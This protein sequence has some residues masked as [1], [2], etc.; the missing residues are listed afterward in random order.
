MYQGTDYG[1]CANK[2]KVGC[3][4]PGPTGETDRQF[5]LNHCNWKPNSRQLGESCN[6]DSQ[7]NDISGSVVGC[8]YNHGNG[9]AFK[10]GKEEYRYS[11]DIQKGSWKDDADHVFYDMKRMNEE[12]DTDQS[13]VEGLYFYR[14]QGKCVYKGTNYVGLNFGDP[15]KSISKDEC[16]SNYIMV[17]GYAKDKDKP[18]IEKDG[19]WSNLPYGCIKKKRIS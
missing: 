11:K 12:P 6:H 10:L 16:A 19:G 8:S 7:C 2:D 9:H 1:T 4:P 5:K 15:D 13:T 3:Y 18:L 14:R 17:D